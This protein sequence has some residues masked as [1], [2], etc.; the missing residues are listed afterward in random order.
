[1]KV[2]GVFLGVPLSPS[3]PSLILITDKAHPAR[4]YTVRAVIN[5]YKHNY[6]STVVDTQIAQ[7]SFPVWISDVLHLSLPCS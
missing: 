4:P 1:M 7:P 3:S 6:S 2:S 5:Y